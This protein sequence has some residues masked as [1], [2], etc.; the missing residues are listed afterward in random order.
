MPLKCFL[1][2]QSANLDPTYFSQMISLAESLIVRMLASYQTVKTCTKK[3]NGGGTGLMNLAIHYLRLL[4]L[5]HHRNQVQQ[6]MGFLRHQPQGS[7]ETAVPAGTRV[8]IVSR[9]VFF[10]KKKK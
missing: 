6:W 9:D 1:K 3:P 10:F 5:S 8:I 7:R 2:Q 4:G